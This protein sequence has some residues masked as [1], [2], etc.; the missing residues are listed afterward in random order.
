MD[1]LGSHAFYGCTTLKSIVIPDGVS[2]IE[3]SAFSGCSSLTSVKLPASVVKIEAEAFSN[4]TALVNGLVFDG[5]MEQWNA[6]TFDPSWRADS[7][8][9]TVRCKNGTATL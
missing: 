5:T 1:V 4:C 3:N 7:P 6:I 2:V 8:F 9:T